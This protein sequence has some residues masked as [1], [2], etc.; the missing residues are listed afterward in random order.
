[1]TLLLPARFSLALM[2]HFDRLIEAASAYPD[3][4]WPSTLDTQTGRPAPAD[5]IPRRVYRLI[6]APGGSTLY[7]DQPL[8]AAAYALSETTGI[9]HYAQAAEQY[10]RAFLNRCIGTDG[11]FLW[12]NHWYYSLTEHT[13]IPFAGGAHELRPITPLWDLFWHLNSTATLTYL[14]P[15]ARRH[16]Y[17]PHQGAF[18]RHDD[19]KKGHAFLEAGGIL[20]E[21]L[22]WLHTKTGEAEWRDLALRIARYNFQYRHP[23]T[24]L[25]P[26]DPDG[27]RWDSRVCTTEVG[28][29]ARS[30][31]R[32]SE[33]LGE[34]ELQQ[35]AE[36]AVRAFLAYGWDTVTERFYGQLAIDTGD[37][38][39]PETPGYWPG[40]HSNPWNNEQWPNHDYPFALAETCLL[41]YQ[42]TGDPLFHNAILRW[43]QTLRKDAPPRNIPPTYAEHYG[44]AIHFLL[45]A[46]SVLNDPTLDQDVRTVAQHAVSSL[47]GNG[48]FQG[49]PGSRLHE[50]VDGLGVLFLALL[51]LQT[52]QPQPFEQ[53]VF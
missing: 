44:R 49:F 22:V 23:K 34:T 47:L 24:G 51:R 39:R 26:N 7:W 46:K 27:G 37:P 16:F 18:N 17:D 11:R 45:G 42:K 35:M 53:V 9:N 33:L 2:N 15:T 50:A 21:S 12:G 1:M 52:S 5:H 20:C 43:I 40:F 6:G 38:I 36:H 30:L 4:L 13:P 29:W 31:L 19:G 8:V 25:V 10:V 3:G 14:G 48:I 41:L 32:A 28:L